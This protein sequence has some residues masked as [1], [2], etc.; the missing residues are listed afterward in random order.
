M[1][2]GNK[3]KLFLIFFVFFAWHTL[4]AVSINLIEG[5]VPVGSPEEMLKEGIRLG[6]SVL[7]KQAWKH[8]ADAAEDNGA[9]KAYLE[10]GKIYF[11]LSLLGQSTQL[12]HD[13]ARDLACKAVAQSPKSSDAHRALG[14]V[15]AGE[16]AF[17]DAYQELTLALYLNPTNEFLIYDL[18]LLHVALKQ[19]EKALDYLEGHN[20]KSAWPYVIMAMANTQM[21]RHGK[22]IV[23]LYKARY[24]G[25]ADSL[26]NSMLEQLSDELEIELK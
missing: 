9:K 22:A 17:L 25:F 18:A 2:I 3:S 23:N 8:Y 5:A 21:K 7:L 15:L 11:Y 6:N 20:Y 4:Q 10:L 19:P 13:T 1:S 24:L 16:G 12:E 14:L 26:I